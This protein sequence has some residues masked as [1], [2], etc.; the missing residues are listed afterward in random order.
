MESE[1]HAVQHAGDTRAPLLVRVEE[2]ARLLDLSRSKVYELLARDELPGVVRIGRSVRIS[3][4]SL[5]QWVD[6]QA[7]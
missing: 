6:A 3:R 2:A 1:K 5:E 4:Q 7:K